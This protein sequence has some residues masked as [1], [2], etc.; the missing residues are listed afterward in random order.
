VPPIFFEVQIGP[1][2]G[3]TGRIVDWLIYGN[4][5]VRLNGD[6]RRL[7]MQ[8]RDLLLIRQRQDGKA[9]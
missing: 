6:Q 8:R 7:E 3:R 5:I 1:F 4:V 2:K 9:A